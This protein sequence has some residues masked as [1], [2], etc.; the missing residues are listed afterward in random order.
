[1]KL[2]RLIYTI[3]FSFST[4]GSLLILYFALVRS[5]LKCAPVACK[6][7][8]FIDSIN[9][10]AY[11]ENLQLLA[12]IDFFEMQ[13]ITYLLEKLNLLILQ[14]RCHHFDAWF[15]IN[16]FSGAKCCPHVRWVPCHHGMACPQVADG[17]D[18]MW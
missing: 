7:V 10:S 18:M 9:L 16:V 12:T 4:T 3:T 5:K 1:M 13:N 15:I 11:K 6:S 17:G 14:I 8:T 2:L